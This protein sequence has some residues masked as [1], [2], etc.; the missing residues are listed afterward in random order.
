MQETFQ[1]SQLSAAL[2]LLIGL[3]FC[4][5]TRALPIAPDH[6]HTLIGTKDASGK[7]IPIVTQSKNERRECAKNKRK[8][9][10]WC[11]SC[12][13]HPRNTRPIKKPKYS[14]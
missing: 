7:P 1:V 13:S 11:T 3:I 10:P 2:F 9:Q 8:F 4:Q 12:C 14:P 6:L 5:Q